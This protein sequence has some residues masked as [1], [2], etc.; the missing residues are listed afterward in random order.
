METIL[1]E[2]LINF[3]KKKHDLTVLRCVYVYGPSGSGKT[4]FVNTTLKKMGYDVVSY[5]AGDVRNKSII[6]NINLSSANVSAM[7]RVGT[8]QKK[9]A[10]VMDEIE[11]MNNGDKGGI[12]ALIKLVR[13]KKTK[14]QMTEEVTHTPIICIGN[15][16]VDKKVAEL[17][18]CSLVIEI[19]KPSEALMLQVVR[20]VL[21]DMESFYPSILTY[22]EGDLKKLTNICNIVKKTGENVVQHFES[23][24]LVEDSKQC[25][26]RIFLSTPTLADHSMI[27]ETD[28]TIVS[29]LWHENVPD[30]LSKVE[31]DSDKSNEVYLELIDNICFADYVDRI[32]F[33]KQAWQMNE[34]SSIIK[35]F[36]VNQIL[37]KHWTSKKKMGDVRFTKMLTKYS[38]EYNNS[39]F[40]LKMCQVLGMDKRD[41][42]AYMLHART[43]KTAEQIASAI[44]SE[45]VT[46]VDINRMFRF[47]DKFYPT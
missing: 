13:P 8:S 33:Q 28:R 17:M 24:P 12:N 30:I 7:L 5:N 9:I 3:E 6:D 22:S 34:M 15:N 19:K 16:H 38:T 46:A 35:T 14:K 44:G 1:E 29:M 23:R 4:R 37:A 18:K 31:K 36:Y 20:Q 42:F 41:M 40:I 26:K 45:E 27:Q 2:F 39:L 11:C 21:P 32:T 25:V 10:V 43:T 47:V